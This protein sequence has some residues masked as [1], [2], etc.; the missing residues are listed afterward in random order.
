MEVGGIAARIAS[1]SAIARSMIGVNV[2][3]ARRLRLE[4]IV[5]IEGTVKAVAKKVRPRSKYFD[6]YLSQVRNH[7]RGMGDKVALQFEKTYHKP[8][9]WMDTVGTSSIEA[10]ELLYV[11]NQFP[12]NE[13]ERI[14]EELK[15][16]LRALKEKE[17][18]NELNSL[19]R[20]NFPKHP[21]R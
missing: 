6:R 14:V 13:Q 17:S 2:K 18:T 19:S 10:R 1:P 4:E 7:V 5:R 3:E 9:G 12:Q 15:I 8:N 11:W 21:H 16:R 20:P